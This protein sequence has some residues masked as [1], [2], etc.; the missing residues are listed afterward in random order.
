MAQIDIFPW[1]SDFNIGIS[2]IDQQHMKLVELLN[3]LSSHLAF[4]STLPSLKVIIEELEAYA[5]YHFQSEEAIWQLHLPIE[6]AVLG[7]KEEHRRFVDSVA[8]LKSLGG[9]EVTTQ[10]VERILTFLARW[11]ISHILENDRYMACMMSCVQSGVPMQ[12]APSVARKRLGETARGLV[13]SIYESLSTNTLN[14]LRELAARQHAESRRLEQHHFTEQL[15]ESI[16]SPLFFKDVQGRYLGCNRAF[17]DYIGQARGDIIGKSAYELSSQELA[18]RYRSADQDLFDNPGVQT[19]EAQVQNAMGELRN[20]QFYKATFKRPDSSLGGLVGVILD[21]TSQCQDKAALKQQLKFAQAL[22]RI[23]KCVLEQNDRLEILEDVACEVGIA[24]AADRALV[25]DISMSQNQA[26]GLCEYLNPEHPDI[27]PTL[28]TYPLNWFISSAEHIQ[29]TRSWLASHHKQVHPLLALDSADKVLHDQMKIKDLLWYPF[30]FH[31]EGFYLLALNQIYGNAAA[32]RWTLEDIKFL[33]SVSHLL[34]VSLEKAKLL[35]QRQHLAFY[36]QLTNLP[37]RRLL[38]DRLEQALALSSRDR[39]FGALIFID[40]DHFKNVND[41]LG[42]HAGDSLLIHVA[43]ELLSCVRDGDTVSRLG[44]DEFVVM[45]KDLSKNEL[46]TATKA[47]VVCEKVI[48]TLSKAYEL[49]R[50]PQHVTSSIGVTLFGGESRDDKDDPLKRAEMAMYQAKAEG[51]NTFRFFDPRMQSELLSRSALQSDLR[52]A[53]LH[54]QFVL[55][56]QAQVV[57]ADRLTGVEALVRWQHPTRGMVPPNDFIP[58]AEEY[59]LILPLGQWVLQTACVQLAQWARQPQTA[60]LTIAVNVSAKQFHHKNFVE[61]VLAVLDETG[62]DPRK[63]KL[64][65]TESLL[66]HDVE[67]IITKM[68]TLKELGVGFSLDDFG[69]GYSSLSY[70]K[71]LPLDQLKI[72]QSFV[73]NVLADSNDAAIAKMVIA[74]SNSLGLTVI[75]E[76]VEAEGQRDFLARHGCH[77]CQGY[78][79]SRPLPIDEFVKLSHLN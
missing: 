26:T 11:L 63:L 65:L 62:A 74:L 68:S 49:E 1:N 47:E 46:E 15:I 2:E 50:I 25:Y 57:G 23:A 21:I 54:E 45:L 10:V 7:H 28:A 41:T 71:R 24:L 22:N 5:V 73:R 33:D 30:A 8:Q 78:L 76:G 20:V 60:H 3:K 31:A 27:P 37:N 61:H 58:L 52:Q 70:L 64:E 9:L 55:H 75:A 44:S 56:Y 19:Y 69:T 40:L 13:L 14:L 48:S 36:D 16:P 17:E 34:S 4:G 66:V 79:F 51:R 18:E 53:I 35:E 43:R 12:D 38:Q 59:G 39:S 42:H 32:S 6:A 67:D 29:K 77:A 72:D